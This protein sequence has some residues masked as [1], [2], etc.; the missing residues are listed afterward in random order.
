V[1]KEE[2]LRR[3]DEHIFSTGLDDSG[4]QLGLANMR[5]GLAKIHWAQERLGLAPNGTFIAAPDLSVTRNRNRWR[6]G[7]GYGGKLT[8][9]EGDQEFIV[10]DVK[11]NCCGMLVGGLDL[12]PSSDSVLQEAQD[13]K[14]ETVFIEGMSIV[15]DLRFHH[16]L[17]RWRVTRAD[18]PGRWPVLGSK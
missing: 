7:F 15:W 1:D 14:R 10:L 13:L 17:L 4:A 11:P 18:I 3:A 9:G 8:W 5:Y 6:S 12:L 2:L 16:T